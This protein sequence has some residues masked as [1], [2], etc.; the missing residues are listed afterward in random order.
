M[1]AEVAST[2]T[3]LHP[4]LFGCGCGTPGVP[5]G[6]PVVG[7]SSMRAIQLALKF[8]L[9]VDFLKQQGD[10]LRRWRES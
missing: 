2:T 5:N 3:I 8:G 10:K 6:N 9:E 7:S 4:G 1:A